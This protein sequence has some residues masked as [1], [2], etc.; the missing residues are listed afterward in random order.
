MFA[1]IIEAQSRVLSFRAE[2]QPDEPH[3][4]LAHITVEKPVEFNDLKTGDS[5]CVDG[6]CLTVENKNPEQDSVLEFSLGR[7]T[8][9][10]TGWSSETL[11]N[12]TVN[13]ERSLKFGDRVHGHFVSG[14]VDATAEVLSLSGEGSVVVEVQ[15]PAPLRPLIYKK[16]S[17]AL[18]GTSLTVNEISDSGVLSVCLIPETL[19][20]TNLGQLKA[21]ARVNIEVDQFARALQRLH[22]AEASL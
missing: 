3:P 14:H 1:G 9:A 16:G 17:V 18:N 8:L 15:V 7:E 19:K 10:V 20:R 13:L 21:G 5:I 11:L 6:V 22:R 2:V 4:T 12:K